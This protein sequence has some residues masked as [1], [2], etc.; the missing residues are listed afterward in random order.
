MITGKSEGK[1]RWEVSFPIHT[2]Q[3]IFIHLEEFSLHMLYCGTLSGFCKP[4]KL[5]LVKIM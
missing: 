1:I 3:T 2:F 5:R 4:N